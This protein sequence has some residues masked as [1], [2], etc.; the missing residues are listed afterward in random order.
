MNIQ[1]STIGFVLIESYKKVNTD[2]GAVSGK[3]IKS[4]NDLF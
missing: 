2:D 4:S 3:K 1:L